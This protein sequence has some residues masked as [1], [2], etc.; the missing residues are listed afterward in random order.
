LIYV[1][2][3]L[4]ESLQTSIEIYV[5]MYISRERE[6]KIFSQRFSFYRGEQKIS[7]S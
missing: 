3:V 5:Y 4:G 6:R 7:S 2:N 1:F